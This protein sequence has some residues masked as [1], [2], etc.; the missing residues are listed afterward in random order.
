[1]ST[2]RDS[3]DL[4]IH[5]E[6]CW[7]IKEEAWK[8][9]NA[10]MPRTLDFILSTTGRHWRLYPKAVWKALGEQKWKTLG[11]L[12]SEHR[13]GHV[14]HGFLG[15]SLHSPHGNTW[16]LFWAL[17]SVGIG[18]AVSLLLLGPLALWP[19]PATWTAENAILLVHFHEVKGRK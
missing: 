7:E 18:K 14:W 19:S 9:Y 5:G 17:T 2:C 10:V 1:M 3:K 8:K 15:A 13:H 12:C 4:S 16:K 6:E 11:S